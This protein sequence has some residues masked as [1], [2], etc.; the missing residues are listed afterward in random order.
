MA[1]NNAFWREVIDYLPNLILVFRIDDQE[2][3]Q[4]IF[5]NKK[6]REQLGYSAREYVLASETEGAIQ[7]E[8][9]KVVDEV[10]RRSHDVDDIEPRSCH[11]TGKQG[12][13]HCYDIDFRLFKTKRNAQLIAVELLSTRNTS[14]ESSSTEDQRSQKAAGEI[15]ES[16]VY[17]SDI[18][19]SVLNKLGQVEEGNKRHLLLQGEA[20]VGKRTL[21]SRLLKRHTGEGKAWQN[22]CWSGEGKTSEVNLPDRITQEDKHLIIK[23]IHITELTPEQQRQ[24]LGVLKEREENGLETWL[25]ATTRQN[26]EDQVEKDQFDSKLYYY[27]GFETI[28]V[29]PLRHR[30]E[31][32][33]AATR[34]YLERAARYLNMD[35]DDIS[36]SDLQ[37]LVD[38]QWTG[39]FP[40][41]FKVLRRSLLESEPETF[42]LRM[43]QKQQFQLFPEQKISEDAVLSFDQMN[44]TYLER[45]LKLTDGKIYG[46][47]GAAAL[48][49]LKPTTLQSKLKRLGIK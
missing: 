37:R 41:L 23:V 48:L 42:Q 13:T 26:L 47:D 22:Y 32:I 38:K 7:R 19:Q 27:I 43:K 20:G 15:D 25:I 46:D 44:R 16:I 2:N 14:K 6:I 11:L 3:A 29:P 33:Q 49:D 12:E 17:E 9:N 31:D 45:V 24:L 4:L 5:C 1:S 40:E 21:V 35:I 36:D 18:M 10:A 39:N 30:P 34:K 28:L 8:I